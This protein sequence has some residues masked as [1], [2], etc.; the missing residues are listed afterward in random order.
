MSL[1]GNSVEVKELK[2]RVQSLEDRIKQKEERIR[3][4]EFQL[5]TKEKEMC[6]AV[7][8]AKNEIRK[9]VQE[10]LI[11]SDMERI[12]AV[13]KLETYEKMNTKDDANKIR[14][15]LDK[16]ITGLTNRADVK[17]VK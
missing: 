8:A 1:F 3:E 2:A 6:L 7:E 14:E 13:S 9:E 16:A 17:V 5:T 11:K 15:M 4:I 12:Q 10:K